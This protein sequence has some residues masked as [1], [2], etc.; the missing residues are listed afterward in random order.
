VR[1]QLLLSHWSNFNDAHLTG[2]EAFPLTVINRG[3]FLNMFPG[4]RWFST[5]AFWLKIPDWEILR[6]VAELHRSKKR[7][8][9]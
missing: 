9:E 8:H 2:D 1:K 4:H 3:G 7:F 6:R 5:G